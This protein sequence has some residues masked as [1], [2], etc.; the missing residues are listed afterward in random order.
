[1]NMRRTTFNPLCTYCAVSNLNYCTTIAILLQYLDYNSQVY[2]LLH[3]QY[4]NT[5]RI[6]QKLRHIPLL[7]EHSFLQI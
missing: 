3:V 7:V 2:L 4:F 6:R 5:P 1:M